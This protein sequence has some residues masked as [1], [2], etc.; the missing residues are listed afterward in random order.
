MN[1]LWTISVI[2]LGII[3]TVVVIY[4]SLNYLI[5]FL[6]K[7]GFRHICNLT[8]VTLQIVAIITFLY[9]LYVITPFIVPTPTIRDI[10]YKSTKFATILVITWYIIVLLEI[11]IK[12]YLERKHIPVL[13]TGISVTIMKTIVLA[14]GILIGLDSIN[15]SITPLITTLGIGGL[16]VALAVQDILGNLFSGII[17]TFGKQIKI[18]DFIKI[19]EETQGFIEDITL[20]TT[21]IKRAFDG[22]I[23][24]VPNSSV[25]NASIINF[26]EG[27]NGSYGVAIPVGVSYDANLKK[28][29]EI[30]MKVA[31]EV[32]DEIDEADRDFEPIMRFES[33]G[34]SAINFKV[35]FKSKSILGRFAIVDRFIEKLKNAYDKEGIVIPYPQQDVYIKEMSSKKE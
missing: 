29:R 1:T 7:K 16:A 28:V 15:I 26:K 23:V 2:I 30:T 4:T 33:F 17:L 27:H 35:L 20:R 5:K 24:I 32:V 10:I 25:V 3:A 22:A 8:N 34:D 6:C 21:V 19:D 31:K 14:T 13:T 18:G 9:A 11:A 12:E